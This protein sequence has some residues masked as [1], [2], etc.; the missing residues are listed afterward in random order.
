[1]FIREYV[2]SD[3]SETAELF[4]NTVHAVNA[5][6]YTEKQLNAWAS[7]NIDI[8][9]WNL[10]LSENYTIVAVEDKVIVGFGDIDKTGYLDRLFVHK[11]FQRRGI[12]TKICNCLESYGKW[13]KV[14]VNASVTAKSFFEKRGYFVVK[15]QRIPRGGV[16]LINF[17]MQKTI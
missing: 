12:A 8:N 1:M 4:Y 15:Q 11:D 3:C 16:H 9:A 2:P 17:A 6:D 13:R 7:K 14:T 5:R 10:S